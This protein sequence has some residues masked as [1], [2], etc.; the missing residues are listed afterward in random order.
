[1]PLAEPVYKTCFASPD[2]FRSGA[3]EYSPGRDALFHVERSRNAN[4]VQYDALLDS[5]GDLLAKEP[6]DGYW[7]RH[8]EQGEVKT[9]T[10]VRK[11]FAYGNKVRISG[12]HAIDGLKLVLRRNSQKPGR[13]PAPPRSQRL[14]CLH[15]FLTINI[16]V[17]AQF[18]LLI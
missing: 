14:F 12:T 16:G 17:P 13:K 8:A 11:K 3:G 1:M 18:S 15:D 5:N 10:W 4:I 6:V 2:V 7:I 9:L